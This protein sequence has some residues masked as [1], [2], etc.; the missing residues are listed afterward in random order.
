MNH[1]QYGRCTGND[2]IN[3][4]DNKRRDEDK[5]EQK[6]KQKVIPL[7]ASS[8]SSSLSS[9][10]LLRRLPISLLCE[11][12]QWLDQWSRISL[13]TCSH[14]Y[15]YI[16]RH[17][18]EASLSGI[19]IRVGDYDNN[20]YYYHQPPTKS[21]N[22]P[23]IHSILPLVTSRLR[24]L[25]I[26]RRW[27]HLYSLWSHI[28]NNMTT[29][30]SSF[31]SSS[32]QL[33]RLELL[34]V[35]NHLDL[36]HLASLSSLRVLILK[37]S[38]DRSGLPP[39]WTGPHP[40]YAHLPQPTESKRSLLPEIPDDIP[41]IE[42]LP[43]S[44]LTKLTTLELSDV[45]LHQLANISSKC[46]LTSLKILKIENWRGQPNGIIDDTLLNMIID[47]WHSLHHLHITSEDIGTFISYSQLISI[48]TS[49][50]LLESFTWH[51]SEIISGITL[52]EDDLPTAT[53]PYTRYNLMRMFESGQYWSH[54][55][56]I[57]WD[58]ST[59]GSII[60][61]VP[62]FAVLPSITELNLGKIRSDD[63]WFILPKSSKQLISLKV[64][65]SRLSTHAVAVL[66]QL[67]WLQKLDLEGCELDN[68]D[69]TSLP[70]LTS[71]VHLT[72]LKM[73]PAEWLPLAPK[74]GQIDAIHLLGAPNLQHLSIRH[75]RINP[76]WWPMIGQAC[77]QL[78][79]LSIHINNMIMAAAVFG[80]GGRTNNDIY[81]EN[82]G[83]IARINVPMTL[84]K[85][86]STQLE[87]LTIASARYSH[88]RNIS[89]ELYD[90]D[91][92]LLI[93]AN[94]LTSLRRVTLNGWH[95][96]RLCDSIA[97]IWDTRGVDVIYINTIPQSN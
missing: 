82:G 13:I 91:E 5:D 25:C 16:S 49:T 18:I 17:R 97:T 55:R 44:S 94:G 40:E 57:D 11:C 66:S 34:A 86:F 58:A 1:L 36:R 24:S 64:H 6:K 14:Y 45:T 7:I 42:R 76:M 84:V 83:I 22:Q 50:P 78:R 73:D 30:S 20:E 3:N 48:M 56:S 59:R 37:D 12:Y 89:P 69:E 39:L 72:S 77:T 81:S 65:W 27:N 80:F 9:A 15:H 26:H 21:D 2:A 41:T 33:T 85:Y 68:N 60:P 74:L 19:T 4:D 28:M 38:H 95:R 8:T 54:I 35:P 29:T 43:L 52:A 92:A 62:P 90:Y 96:H 93:L 32:I 47:H 70:D 67:T 46:Q 79:S 31:Q 53:T 51:C 87:S 88:I 71:L 75:A 61:T 63:D 10:S 23:S